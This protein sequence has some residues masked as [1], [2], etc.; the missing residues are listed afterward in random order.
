M[1]ST[2][3]E[4]RRERD[5]GLAGKVAVVTG[6]ASGIGQAVALTYVRAGA[7]TVLGCLPDDAHDVGETVARVEAAGARGSRFPLT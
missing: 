1:G 5:D 7:T 3:P 4:V 2:T 6:A